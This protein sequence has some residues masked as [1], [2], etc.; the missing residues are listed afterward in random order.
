MHVIGRKI[1]YFEKVEELYKI[2]F[3]YTTRLGSKNCQENEG[4]LAFRT[5]I[6]YFS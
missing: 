2:S 1:E 6:E 4:K 3:L 5:T